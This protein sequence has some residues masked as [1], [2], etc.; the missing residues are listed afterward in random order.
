MHNPLIGWGSQPKN[1]EIRS[2]VK[3]ASYPL[4]KVAQ[5]FYNAAVL[6]IL[7]RKWQQ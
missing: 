4:L 6:S 3:A 7:S 5:H 1:S 2:T